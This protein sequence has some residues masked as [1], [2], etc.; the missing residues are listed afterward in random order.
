MLAIFN[1]FSKTYYVIV[2]P[3]SSHRN[4]GYDCFLLLPH[5]TLLNGAIMKCR[6]SIQ[7]T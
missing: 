5:S 7:R 4:D 1:P 3:F 6:S 2:Y